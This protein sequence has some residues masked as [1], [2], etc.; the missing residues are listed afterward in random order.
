MVPFPSTW[1][2]Y[3]SVLK[4]SHRRWCVAWSDIT[5]SQSSCQV[6]VEYWASNRLL[7]TYVRP[8]AMPRMHLTR[9]IVDAVIHDVRSVWLIHDTLV[10]LVCPCADVIVAMVTS[11]WTLLCENP[12]CIPMFQE[13]LHFTLF[14]I[15]YI[16]IVFKIGNIM[17]LELGG[18]YIHLSIT[19]TALILCSCEIRRKVWPIVQNIELSHTNIWM[20]NDLDTGNIDLDVHCDFFIPFVCLNYVLPTILN[21]PFN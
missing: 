9:L 5:P 14:V 10:R 16:S 2:I 13:N 17:L 7:I 15:V 18:I 20:Q 11:R 6:S 21:L 19:N 3:D 1:H 4:Q 8:V 12:V